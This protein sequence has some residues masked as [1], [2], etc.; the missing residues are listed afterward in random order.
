VGGAAASGVA[1]APPPPALDSAELAARVTASTRDAVSH[2]VTGVPA[3]VVD[4][5]LL[6]PGAQPHEV[7]DMVMRRLGHRRLDE[8]G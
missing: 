2:G 3:W 6:V 1:G 7:F 4:R 8:P 5:R